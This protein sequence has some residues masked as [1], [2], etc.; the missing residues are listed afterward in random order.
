[1]NILLFKEDKRENGYY[2]FT[3]ESDGHLTAEKRIAGATDSY[4]DALISIGRAMITHNLQ[5]SKVFY[6]N[7][8]INKQTWDMAEKAREIEGLIK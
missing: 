4:D 5:V 3:D 8:Q 1:M 6:E 7:K 2:W